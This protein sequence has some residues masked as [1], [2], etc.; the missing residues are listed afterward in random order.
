MNTS[1]LKR[2]RRLWSNPLAAAETNR[3]NLREWVRAIRTVG[4]KWLLAEHVQRKAS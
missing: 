3:R 2:G 1:M 4:D